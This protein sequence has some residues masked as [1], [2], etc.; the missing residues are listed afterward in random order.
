M[1]TRTV[2][3][4][5]VGIDDYQHPVPPLRGCVNDIDAIES[6]LRA[7]VSG[8]GTALDLVA[9]RNREATRDAVI[10]GFREHLAQAG[11]L[12]V[13]LFYYSGHGSQEEAPPEFWSVEPDHLDETLVLYDSR[14]PEHYDLADKELAKLIAEVA[15]TEPHILV[16]L[17]CCHSGSGT[18][19]DVEDGTAIRRAP[20]DTR[21]RPLETFLFARDEAADLAVTTRDAG[22]ARS[23]W[24]TLPNARHVLLS[25]CR[26]SETSKEVRYEGQHRGALSVGL[27][28][29]LERAGEVLSYQDLH[30]WALADV[31]NRVA[32]QTPQLEATSLA[33][34]DLTFLGGAAASR[35][36]YATLSHDN[37]V[38]WVVDVGAIHG[39]PSPRAD[40]SATF[41]VFTHD[42]DLTSVADRIGAAT[43]TKVDPNQSRVTVAPTGDQLDPAATYKAV[44]V[45]LPLDPVAVSLAGDPDLLTAL[46]AALTGGPGGASLLV[47][48]ASQATPAELTVEATPTGYRITRAASTRPLVADITGDDAA[49]RAVAALEHMARWARLAEL[50]NPMTQLPPDGVR[51]TVQP[52]AGAAEAAHPASDPHLRLQYDGEKAPTFTLAVKNTTT[53]TLYCAMLD[54]TELYGVYSATHETAAVELLPGETVT[55]LDGKPLA[56][57]IPGD[58]HAEGVTELTDVL[59]VVVSTTQFDVRALLQDDLNLTNTTRAVRGA[60]PALDSTFDRLFNRIALRHIGADPGAGESIADWLTSDVIVTVTRPATSKQIDAQ[61]AAQLHAGFVIE[62]HA[63]LRAEARLAH[64]AEVDRGVEAPVLPAVLRDDTDSRPFVL[65]TT[66]STVPNF[67]VLELVGVQNADAVTRDAPLRI[68]VDQP[69][70]ADEHLLALAFDGEAY[71]PLG[72]GRRR[73]D[74]TDIV[75]ERLP[76]PLA[77]TRDLRGSVSILFRKLVLRRIGVEYNYPL[78]RLATVEGDTLTCDGDEAHVRDAVAA[79]NRVVVYVHGIIGDTEGMARSSAYTSL[80]PPPPL[81]GGRYDCVLTFDHENLDT[82][83]EDNAKG[84]RDRLAAVGLAAGHGKELD[85]VAHSMGGLVSRHFIEQLGGNEVVSRL[86]TLGTPNGG[87]PWPSVQQWATAMLAFGLNKLGEVAWPARIMGGLIGLIE[88]VDTALDEM[89]PGSPFLTQL[90]GAPDPRVRYHVIVGRR[91]LIPQEKDPERTGYIKRL[92]AKLS[93]ARIADEALEKLFAGDDNDLAV[94]VSSAKHLPAGRDPEPAIAEV[95]CDHVSYFSTAAGLSALAAALR[96]D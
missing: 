15:A 70:G 57:F 72:Y 6:W 42:A 87:S 10:R 58:L 34:L 9:L 48:E 92:L 1:A 56:A 94:G 47:A 96:E 50:R 27:Q 52:T 8:D 22:A 23:D 84:L 62:P 89:T 3:G 7:R 46:R 49:E 35:P 5:L 93:P 67:D 28:Q 55:A 77:T 26:A 75:I 60:P 20:L 91:S 69:I 45:T 2:Y 83:I 90:H 76:E 68:A 80:A 32:Q 39:V 59:K 13:A 18:R 78:L 21:V 71:L 17:D 66:R 88:R 11:P 37:A 40:E 85:I 54:L 43:V 4:L 14:Q 44:L 31:R 33:D 79:A 64:V 30:R 86:V 38:G 19:A 29:G 53:R 24:F 63:T 51:I 41:S 25:G 16:V 73:V 95:A 61:A 82:A 81:I 65:Q 12:D 74:G 36:T